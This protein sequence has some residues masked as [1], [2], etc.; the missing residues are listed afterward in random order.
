M[1]QENLWD[2]AQKRGSEKVIR[3]EVIMRQ[4]RDLEGK[5]RAM[6]VQSD[7]GDLVLGRLSDGNSLS[8]ILNGG[9]IRHFG[10][11]RD[12]GMLLAL[13]P[14]RFQRSDRDKTSIAI[15]QSSTRTIYQTL[16]KGISE[17]AKGGVREQGK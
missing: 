12:V 2:T 8:N 5:V 10:C 6:F 17:N 3:R 11:K 16:M 9:R 13:I 15:F 14:F 7:L 4:M 1:I